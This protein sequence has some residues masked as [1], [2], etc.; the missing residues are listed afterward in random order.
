[1]KNNIKTLN[2]NVDNKTEAIL[3]KYD[4]DLYSTI[5]IEDI[6]LNEEFNEDKLLAYY[7]CIHDIYYD[8]TNIS[9]Y[10]YY[11]NTNE[12]IKI[13]SRTVEDKLLVDIVIS[14]K[15]I[16]DNIEYLVNKYTKYNDNN[17]NGFYTIKKGHFGELK[18]DY[19]KIDKIIVTDEL[20]DLY[21]QEVKGYK[22]LVDKL[23]NENEGLFLL[24][25][26]PGSGKSTLLEYL[27][28][29]IDIN[30]KI[31]FIPSDMISI[32]TS[33]DFLTFITKYKNSILIL[34]DAENVLESR[35]VSNSQSVG[36]IL[37]ITSG[38]L[39]KS[40]GIQIIATFNTGLENID[41]ALLR[42]GRLKV[43]WRFTKLSIENGK[44]LAKHLGIDE[45]LINKEMT[46][47]EISH[48]DEIKNINKTE[49]I[50][51]GF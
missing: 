24:H 32:F 9:N 37:N 30:K 7:E 19:N 28:S 43:N 34:E 17:S 49:T 15:K 3:Y 26:I 25:G 6:G 39:N 11:Y 41:S 14:Y 45:N 48:L 8:E 44:K 16:N 4:F 50:T 33:P 20:L 23:N 40:L 27:I 51:I 36:N 1:M 18:L 38:L 42:S 35:D 47:S 2:Y 29:D 21:Y 31:I 22:I 10:F 12:I 5:T 13:T 46:V